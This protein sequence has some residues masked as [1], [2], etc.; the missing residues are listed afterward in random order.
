M[1]TT[2]IGGPDRPAPWSDK[3]RLRALLDEL[4]DR[5]PH[6]EPNAMG[7]EANFLGEIDEALRRLRLLS[8]R[9]GAP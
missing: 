5:F 8:A 6:I 7:A 4:H 2:I 1:T 3:A 9:G